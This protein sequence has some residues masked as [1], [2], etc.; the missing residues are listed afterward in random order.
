MTNTNELRQ[1]RWR[2][3]R[4][5]LIFWASLPVVALIAWIIVVPTGLGDRLFGELFG[6]VATFFLFILVMVIIAAAVVEIALLLALDLFNN[7]GPKVRAGIP[8]AIG[9][10]CLLLWLTNPYLEKIVAS[11]LAAVILVGLYVF[12]LR[13]WKEVARLR[14]TPEPTLPQ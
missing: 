7:W 2:T 9:T 10:I 3:L 6:W 11:A 12:N 4:G 13:Y 14:P 8:S 1:L 5:H